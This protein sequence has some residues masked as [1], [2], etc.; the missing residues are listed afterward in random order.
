MTQSAGFMKELT[1][2]MNEFTTVDVFFTK[3]EKLVVSV[4]CKEIKAVDS[5]DKNMMFLRNIEDY[6]NEHYQDSQLSPQQIAECFG[7]S[8][9]YLPRKF[10]LLAGVSLNSYILQVRMSQAQKLLTS[11]DMPISEIANLVGIENESYFYK[12]FKKHCGCTPKEYKNQLN[13]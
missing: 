13:D 6:I 4:A 3:L 11:S 8:A 5:R 2:I 10:Q 9:N 7:V 1:Q 12:L